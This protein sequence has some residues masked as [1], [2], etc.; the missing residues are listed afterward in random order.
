M[1]RVK[2]GS[3]GEGNIMSWETTLLWLW[4]ISSLNPFSPLALVNTEYI[5]LVLYSFVLLPSLLYLHTCYS[6]PNFLVS[7]H[8]LSEHLL[9]GLL[10]S[11]FILHWMGD[12]M[13]KS[14]HWSLW[15]FFGQTLHMWNFPG[16]GSNQ[17]CNS[18]LC[19]SWGNAGCLTLWA[20][21]EL[22]LWL[23]FFDTFIF[24]FIYLFIYFV[25]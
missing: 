7:F 10:I 22:S 25:F 2:C 24:I 23:L 13:G 21:K 1:I 6:I 12:W 14:Q 20:T 17:C 4:Y 9:W 11:A 19:H 15:L 5:T 8:S 16:Q 3:W 18:H